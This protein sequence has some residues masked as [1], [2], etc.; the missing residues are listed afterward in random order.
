VEG[1]DPELLGGQ[2][3]QGGEP[4][5]HLAGGLVGEGDG[6]DVPGQH[7]LLGH[8]AGDAADDDAG[9]PG[10]GAGQHQQ[11]PFAVQHRLALRIVQAVEQVGHRG[12]GT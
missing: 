12:G 5:L 3:E 7:P 4:G 8:Q 6:E 11:R 2:A 1:L 10:A 9:L